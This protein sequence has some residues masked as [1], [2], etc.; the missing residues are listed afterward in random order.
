MG[1]ATFSSVQR[2]ADAYPRC[3]KVALALVPAL[4]PAEHG[5]YSWRQIRSRWLRSQEIRVTAMRTF[6]NHA[7]HEPPGH[8]PLAAWLSRQSFRRLTRSSGP[9]TANR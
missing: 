2:Q 5:A 6:Q 4:T 9:P 7:L 3:R 1:Y 8:I